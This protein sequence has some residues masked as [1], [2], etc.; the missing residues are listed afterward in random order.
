LVPYKSLSRDIGGINKYA[1]AK[2]IHHKKLSVLIVILICICTVFLIYFEPANLSELIGSNNI[3][4]VRY[5]SITRVNTLSDKTPC[6]IKLTDK[7]KC[8]NLLSKLSSFPM[9]KKIK[10]SKILGG[11][12]PSYTDVKERINITIATGENIDNWKQLDLY[13]IKKPHGLQLFESNSENQE[14]EYEFKI[15]NI[16]EDDEEKF[17]DFLARYVQSY[18]S[19]T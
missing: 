15:G 4:N 16:F 10:W 9:T 7:N 3:K 11:G 19:R 6:K 18:I 1:G 5:I 13:I 2:I 14:H 8:S 17:Y 12:V